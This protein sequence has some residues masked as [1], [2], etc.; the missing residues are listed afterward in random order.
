MNFRLLLKIISWLLFVIILLPALLFVAIQIKPAQNFINNKISDFLEKQLN[1]S[2][3]IGYI[4]YEPPYKIVLKNFLIED[5]KADTLFFVN[6]IKLSPQK[7]SIKRNFFE[8]D[9]IEIQ[10]FRFKYIADSNGYSNLDYFVDN[11][12]ESKNVDTTK[13]SKPFNLLIKKIIIRNSSFLYDTQEDQ[14]AAIGLDFRHL[15]FRRINLRMS[16]FSIIDDSI[17]FS[18]QNMWAYEKSGFRIRHLSADFFFKDALSFEKLVVSSNKSQIISNLI[19]IKPYQNAWTDYDNLVLNLDIADFSTF[20][21][22]DLSYFSDS[23]RNFFFRLKFGIDSKGTLGDYKINDCLIKYANNTQVIFNG[24]LTNLMDTKKAYFDI[25]LVK[26]Y[27]AK[28][29]IEKISS[30]FTHKKVLKIPANISLPEYIN[31]TGNFVGK[32]NDFS[33][34]T[35]ISTN[36]GFI[37][38]NVSYWS[39]SLNKKVN[40]T[41]LVDEIKL[42]KLL[43]NNKLSNLSLKDTFYLSTHKDKIK[44]VYNL[45]KISSYRFN[46]YTYSNISVIV[47]KN[48][49]SLSAILNIDDENIKSKI[50]LELLEKGKINT[51]SFVAQI[52]T[53]KFYP[54]KLIKDDKY[55]SLSMALKGNFSFKDLNTLVLN[56]GLCK[57]I[58][59]IKNLQYLKIKK[60]NLSTDYYVDSDTIRKIQADN[61]FFDLYTIGNLNFKEIL[62]FASNFIYQYLPAMSKQK[63]T[64]VF[65]VQHQKYFEYKAKIKN[66]GQFQEIFFPKYTISNNTTI[67]GNFNS[68]KQFI[69]NLNSDSLVFSKNKIF[70]LKF[71]IA[72]DSSKLITKIN[73]DTIKLSQL[74]FRNFDFNCQTQKNSTDI[75]LKWDN[76]S[77]PINKGRIKAF[78][79]LLKD[80]NNKSQIFANISEDTVIIDN[81]LWRM[82]AKHIVSDSNG[83]FID[84]F[85][86]RNSLFNQSVYINGRASKSSED[87]LKIQI[88]NFNISQ[89]NPLIKKASLN[90]NLFLNASISRALDTPQIQMVDSIINISINNAK[91]G[92]IYQNIIFNNRTNTVE[93]IT[94][95]F[96]SNA[97]KKDTNSLILAS[98]VDYNLNNKKYNVDL[99]IRK[100][101]FKPFEPFYKEY[102]LFSSTSNLSGQMKISGQSDKFKINGDISVF[103]A[104]YILQ[105]GIT[106][107]INGGMNI[108]ATENEIKI[109]KTVIVGPNLVGDAT[110]YGNIKHKNF[111]DPY[112]NIT[113]KA[114]TIPVFKSARSSKTKYFGNVFISGLLNIKGYSQSVTINANLTTEE[115]TNFTFIVD[116]PSNISSKTNIV[117]FTTDIPDIDTNEFD[118]KDVTDVKQVQM[119]IKIDF[120]IN[121]N[122]NP[123]SKF[124]LFINESLNEYIELQTS[125]NLKIKQN[126]FGDLILF[127][128]AEIEKGMYNFVIQN[129]IT[130][131]FQIQKGSSIVFNGNVMDAM[132]DI[133]TFY[134]IRNVSLYN[135]FMEDSYLNSKTQAD[136]YI[137]I[138]GQITKPHIKFDVQLPQTEKRINNQLQA[139]DENEINK[140]FVSLLAFGRFQPLPGLSYDPNAEQLLAGSFNP[141]EIISNQINSILSSFNTNI[142]LNLNYVSGNSNTSDEYNIGLTIPLLNNRLN[143]TTDLGY[144]TNTNSNEQNQI[145]GDFEATYKLDKTGNLQLK[146]F[147]KNDQLNYY[148]QGYSQGIGFLYTTTLDN[149]FKKQNKKNKQDTLKNNQ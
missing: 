59:L 33:L 12:P 56:I 109:D 23:L 68:D 128:K 117:T 143:I 74:K 110:L 89:V 48:N 102:I 28:N 84:N 64:E 134:T 125:G 147:N 3:R 126:P 72:A 66:L 115:N 133:S 43:K 65:N 54:L 112:F 14:T 145:V 137:R 146:G 34:L 26:V 83:I 105:T 37:K 70:N 67:E 40:G 63:I 144:K 113:L 10:N 78:I 107:T 76:N 31:I 44:N 98:K 123:N 55:A 94:N 1:S 69:F 11:L 61:D 57:P 47:Q 77:T 7:F 19:Y 122:L 138:D 2:V 142:D 79:Q 9:K 90:G 32:I 127:G 29:D 38:T 104:F 88:N 131:K 8:I 71:L 132:L 27:V 46:D 73:T 119:P 36:I 24:T 100:I 25:N 80:S 35:N 111:K 148:E 41:V 6:K 87:T 50:A 18:I 62:S 82:S 149:L 95:I 101:L 86:A 129:I 22:S 93:L 140:Q 135:L 114:D 20:D 118:I 42:D 51:G 85:F 136:C 15:D 21:I 16:N 92:N 97:N 103:G 30:P 5:F 116:R 58:H 13:A 53:I 106:Y 121:L 130:R 139:L 49:D 141:G 91:V 81:I 124:K 99:L 52:D 60:F 4:Y 96:K 17:S 75:V 120:D 39:D 45:L 108:H